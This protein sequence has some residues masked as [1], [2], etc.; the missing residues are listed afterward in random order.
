MKAGGGGGGRSG[1]ETKIEYPYI[2]VVI[3]M[4]IPMFT[5][6]TTRV[7]EDCHGSTLHLK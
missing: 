7:V 1:N 4:L 3:S 5:N 6:Y 2:K